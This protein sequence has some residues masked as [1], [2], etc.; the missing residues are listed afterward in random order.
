MNATPEP[1]AK[2]A[3]HIARGLSPLRAFIHIWEI[4]ANRI[5]PLRRR[6]QQSCYSGQYVASAW[7]TESVVQQKKGMLWIHY[8]LV[9]A[10]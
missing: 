10:V 1:A 6:C 7:G 8:N 9:N 2:E 5:T 4:K 3:A